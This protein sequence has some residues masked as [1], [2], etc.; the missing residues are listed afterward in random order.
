LI[1]AIRGK[2]F[3]SLAVTDRHFAGSGRTIMTILRA[4]LSVG[5][6]ACLGSAAFAQQGL[7]EQVDGPVTAKE[8]ASVKAVLDGVQP[9]DSNTHNNYAYGNGGHAIEASID[10]YGITHDRAFLD[11][12]ISF[13]D[14]LVSIRNHDRVMW[15][16][17]IDPIWPNSPNTVWGCEQG[18]VAGHLAFAAEV[19]AKDKALWDAK[20][21]VGD[22]K[23]YGATYRLRAAHYLA[24]VDETVDLFYR[25]HFIRADETMFTPDPP[26]W[27]DAHS[28]SKP[29]PWN[30]QNMI[31]SSLVHGANAHAAFGDA[32]ERVV[33]YRKTATAS[34][35]R[36]LAQCRTFQSTKNG[37]AVCKWS[38]AA[39]EFAPGA[40]IR[41]TEDTPHG[42][43]DI[44]ALWRAYHELP[45][46]VSAD[47]AMMVANTLMEVIVQP[48]GFAGR[49]DGTGN[50]RKALTNSWAY[51]SEWRPEAFPALVK[52]GPIAY[53]D[54]ARY[55]WIK[56]ARAN[57]WPKPAAATA[58]RSTSNSEH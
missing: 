38:Y 51:L 48:N 4:W 44:T 41:Y 58:E 37:R 7:I 35:R 29:V 19:I 10:L 11:R 15:T 47:D 17:N 39:N 40:P 27:P 2:K 14:Q 13:C 33:K 8:I 31:C 53:A 57:G 18:D 6:A 9:G 22:P 24:V 28:A 34:I 55:L 54:A 26:Q 30:Q 32:P 46:A 25:H 45:G 56:H 16:G 36:F 3:A 1:R 20:P 5:V 42:G 12:L 49:V 52:A 23:G 43:Y 50:P 21:G